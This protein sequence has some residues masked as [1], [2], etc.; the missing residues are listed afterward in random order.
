M[1]TVAERLLSKIEPLDNGCWKYLGGLN[2][3]GYGNIWDN[4]RT[5]SAH[6]VSF[7][8]HNRPVRQG[9]SVCHSCDNKWCIN[10]EHLFEG[11]TQDN[12]DDMI[13]K[14][15]DGFK[16][17]RNGMA[18][19]DEEQVEVIRNL[20]AEDQLSQE[21]IGERFGVSRSTVAAIKSRRLWK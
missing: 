13:S 19:L 5:R 4:G 11:T 17:V 2:Q 1:S 3:G 16:G 21:A 14:G 6:V 12:I 9:Y 20:L 7:E 15:R 8:I 10:P 18:I